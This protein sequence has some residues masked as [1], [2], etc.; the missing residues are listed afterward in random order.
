M[1]ADHSYF[2]QI[3]EIYFNLQEMRRRKKAALQGF[4]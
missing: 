2:L 1:V 3:E 4:N